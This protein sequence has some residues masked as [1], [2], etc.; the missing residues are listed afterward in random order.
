MIP[1][2]LTLVK[3]GHVYAPQD[4]GRKDLLLAGGKIVAIEDSI[5][6]PAGVPGV[7]VVDAADKFVVP[8]FIDSHVHILGGGGE[9]GYHTRTPEIRPT[10]V[11]SAGV[12]TVVGVI[13]TDG[14][15]RTM[16]S[17]IVKARSLNNEGITCYAHTGNYHVPIKTLT[18]RIED[19]L[20]LVDLILGVGEVAISD[21]RSSQPTLDDLAKLASAARIGGM[22]S[23]KAGVVNVHVGDGKD[24]LDPLLNVVE[25]TE[26]PITQ[27]AP[28]HIN[29]GA[30]LFEA[31]VEYARHGGYVDFTTSTTEK[32]LEEGEVK[33]S[34]AIKTML[35]KD[36]PLNRITLTSDA[37]GSLP[38]FDANGDFVGLGVGEIGSLYKETRDA[39]KDEGIPPERALQAITSTPARILKLHHKGRLETGR[40]ADL[41]LLEGESL[42]IDGVFA[43]GQQMVE[44]GRNVIAGTFE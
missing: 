27:F 32:F 35:E 9:G 10:D 4:L 26:V 36:V 11:T 16:A 13:G 15:S 2:V 12:T 21:H 41:V 6:P 30:D 19:D 7:K 23:G 40:D 33:C 39:I 34:R 20:L 14:T 8:G 17:L 31:G 43:R 22:L 44:E 3:N 24:R 38:E 29:R 42:E 1:D 28:T 37:Q 5:E 25:Q 18:G